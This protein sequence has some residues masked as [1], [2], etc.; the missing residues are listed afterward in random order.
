MAGVG[1]QLSVATHEP[2]IAERGG[3]AQGELMKLIEGCAV[4][5]VEVSRVRVAPTAKGASFK[6]MDT[7]AADP[8]RVL[9]RRRN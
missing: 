8:A 3:S 1:A 4:E 9:R 6:A 2:V 5:Q 7:P